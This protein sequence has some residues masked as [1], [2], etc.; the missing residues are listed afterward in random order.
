MLPTALE[1]YTLLMTFYKAPAKP[2][3]M[4]GRAFLPALLC[5]GV[6]AAEVKMKRSSLLWRRGKGQMYVCSGFFVLNIRSQVEK[7]I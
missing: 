5:V 3:G 7:E 1:C 4:G 6:K 2:W